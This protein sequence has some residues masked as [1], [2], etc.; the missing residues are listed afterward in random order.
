LA[1][2]RKDRDPDQIGQRNIGGGVNLY[3]PAREIE[4]G[5][6]LARDVERTASIIEDPVV[7]E[8]VNRIVQNLTLNSDSRFS[9]SIKIV[10]SDEANAFAL[11]GGF[12][13]VNTGLIRA[14]ENEAELASALAH[15]IA[16]V[17][18]R[19]Y[20]R[21]ATW[22]ELATYSGIPLVFIG[23][24]PAYVIHQAIT[25]GTPLLLQKTSR[26]AE[27]Q[28]DALGLQYV[29]KS[30]YDPLAFIDFFERVEFTRNSNPGVFIR[31][32]SIHP[33]PQTR[34]RAAQKQIQRDFLPHAEYVLQTSEFLAI[35]ARLAA[36]ERGDKMPRPIR[37][38]T[39]PDRPPV[40][41]RCDCP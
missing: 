11:P 18:A 36:I 1:G 7:S 15:E 26:S 38:S 31:L 9:C 39:A 19:H 37:G 3:S 34:V 40:L 21:R 30:G 33:G 35:K 28:A 24:V 10:R 14:V 13:Y 17:A 23:G 20:T 5:R 2:P 25:F 32:L 29:Y 16:H 4:L 41:K 12:I 6:D 8:Y 27:L 22:E